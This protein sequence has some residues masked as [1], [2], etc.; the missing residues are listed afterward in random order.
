MGKKKKSKERK[1]KRAPSKS[2]HKKV[3]V[4]TKYKD[5]KVQGKFC[6]RCGPGVIL[7]KHKNRVT[8][9]RCSYSEIEVAKK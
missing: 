2:K 4:W 3:Q 9:G 1:G 5:G 8:C 6:P 7:A